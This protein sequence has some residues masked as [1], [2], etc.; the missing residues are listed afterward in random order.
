MK[1]N[2]DGKPS[3][4]GFCEYRDPETVEAAMKKFQNYNFYGRQL[5]IG[6]SNQARMQKNDQNVLLLFII[7]IIDESRKDEIIRR[8]F[9]RKFRFI[10][11]A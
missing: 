6:Y 9:N 4:Y 11:K 8:Y 5:K 10:H 2:P 1:K 7:T 3:G